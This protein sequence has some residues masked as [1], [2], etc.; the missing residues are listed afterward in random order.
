MGKY[1]ES[2]WIKGATH[3]WFIRAESLRSSHVRVKSISAARWV[4]RATKNGVDTRD[5]ENKNVTIRKKNLPNHPETTVAC[6][7]T[8]PPDGCRAKVIRPQGKE[9]TRCLPT[10]LIV[11]DTDGKL[12]PSL[13]TRI[14]TRCSTGPIQI[15]TRILEGTLCHGMRE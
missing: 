11:C 13:Q 4:D 5:R 10:F 6:I 1:M 15:H 7:F 2:L 14:K 12:F 3:S 9:M 8:E